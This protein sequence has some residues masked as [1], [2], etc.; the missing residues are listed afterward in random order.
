MFLPFRDAVN[1]NSIVKF[2][3]YSR[4]IWYIIRC[5]QSWDSRG[6]SEESNAYHQLLSEKSYNVIVST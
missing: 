2:D 4:F 6:M 5:I 3:A 1:S